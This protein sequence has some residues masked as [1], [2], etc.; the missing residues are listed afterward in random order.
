[1]T[2]KLTFC[3]YCEHLDELNF[4]YVIV[5][6]AFNNL[7]L[8]QVEKFKYKI[9]WHDSNLPPDAN[10][11]EEM[12]RRKQWLRIASN[13]KR[14]IDFAKI[15]SADTIAIFDSDI[16]IPRLDEIIVSNLVY[17]PCYWLWYS[18]ANEIRPF[19]SGTNFIMNKWAIDLFNVLLNL[20]T[21]DSGPIDLYLHDHLPHINVL[22][23]GTI[24]YVKTPEG[25]KKMVMT[26]NDL[27]IIKKHIPELVMVIP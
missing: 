24:H 16:I 11:D 14:A 19:C 5:D 25:I 12:R 23:N 17:T 6:K 21:P 20:Y 27:D 26:I 15:Q 13:L 9:I 10:D 22:V 18:W 4:D 8:S 3:G 7:T 2:L 1:M